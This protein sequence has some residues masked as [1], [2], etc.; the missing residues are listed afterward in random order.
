MS[1]PLAIGSKA[2][3]FELPGVDGK[4]WHLND[5]AAARILVVCFTCN[6]CPYVVGNEG[7]ERAFV[8]KY[9]PR[10]VGYVAI[11][12][13]DAKAFPADDF[14]PMKDRALKLGFAWPY[15][16]DKTQSAAKAYGAIKTPHFFVFDKD[17]ILR[18]VGRMDNSPRDP[19][20]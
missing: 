12:S 14:G 9:A 10:G 20:L 6:H 8:Q 1:F 16:H 13:N 4:T 19:S 7:R 11:N 18:Y 15:L 17:R 2:P 5:F 3:A